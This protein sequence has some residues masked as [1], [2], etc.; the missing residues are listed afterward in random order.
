M[1][2][3]K[4]KE[5]LDKLEK[6]PPKMIKTAKRIIKQYPYISSIAVAVVIYQLI[7]DNE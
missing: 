2:D 1:N 5:Q 3:L 4:I 6:V 7:K